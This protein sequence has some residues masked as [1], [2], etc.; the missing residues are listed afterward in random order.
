FVISTYDKNSLLSLQ[1]NDSYD[2]ILG[3]AKSSSVIL[4]YFA[5]ASNL[6]PRELAPELNDRG[7]RR[8]GYRWDRFKAAWSRFYFEDRV[9]PITPA[10]LK[11]AQD[12]HVHEV[13][14]MASSAKTEEPTVTEV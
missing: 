10:E 7:V 1:R 9:E 11:E 8:K 4:K 6:K 5:D 2:G 14:H 3:E 13:E 12:H